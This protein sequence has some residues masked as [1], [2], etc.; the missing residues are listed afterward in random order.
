MIEDGLRLFECFVPLRYDRVKAD[1]K[2]EL[3]KAGK[4]V[5]SSQAY[6]T[7]ES[8]PEAAVPLAAFV[9]ALAAAVALKPEKLPPPPPPPPPVVVAPPPPAAPTLSS[10]DLSSLDLSKL[11]VSSLGLSKL[12][13]VDLPA[14]DASSVDLSALTASLDLSRLTAAVDAAAASLN[15]LALP[16]VDASAFTKAVDASLA[17]FEL[18]A[19][20]WG[21]L[22]AALP[23]LSKIDLSAVNVDTT[24]VVGLASSVLATADGGLKEASPA[25]TKL[26]SDFGSAGASAISS[27]TQETMDLINSADLYSLFLAGIESFVVVLV[28][29]RRRRRNLRLGERRRGPVA[30]PPRLPRG[31]SAEGAGRGGAASEGSAPRLRLARFGWLLAVLDSCLRKDQRQRRR[32]SFLRRY[33]PVF[34]FT[35]ASALPAE[36]QFVLALVIA[37]VAGAISSRANETE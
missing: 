19:D 11:D 17:T 6:Q 25:I 28:Y 14:F 10:L 32:A 27:S 34:A 36:D 16:D 29:T 5:A 3:T 33:V 21:P 15:G 18:Q 26:V 13:T 9:A 31:Y 4:A 1:P 35:F 7:L 12:P 8:K 37:I 22:L 20:S 23:D 2:G 30:A 24:A